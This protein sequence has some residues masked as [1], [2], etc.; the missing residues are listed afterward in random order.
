MSSFLQP[1]VRVGVGCIITSKFSPRNTI[2]IGKR[3]GSTGMEITSN[4]IFFH[5]FFNNQGNG[6]YALP[7]GHLEVNKSLIL[8]EIC[9]M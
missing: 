7:G 8:L 3:I 6:T 4:N 5:F 9:L 1:V 2:L